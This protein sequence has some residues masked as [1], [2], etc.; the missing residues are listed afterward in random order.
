MSQPYDGEG[1]RRFVLAV[2]EV[3]SRGEIQAHHPTVAGRGSVD[4]DVG[5]PMLP[6]LHGRA[7]HRLGRDLVGLLK[8][9]REALVVVP[10][11]FPALQ[12]V[13][14][15]LT[16]SDDPELGDDEHVGGEGDDLLAGRRR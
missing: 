16:T 6:E 5:Q 15:L 14:E 10:V 9:A 7:A 1:L 8:N 11:D 13:Q 12:G 4:L 2:D 3:A